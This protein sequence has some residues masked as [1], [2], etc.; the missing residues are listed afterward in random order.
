LRPLTASE[1]RGTWGTVL[2]PIDDHERI[3]MA[4]LDAE[5]DALLASGVNGIYTNGTAGE[6]YTQTEAEFDRIH[7]RIAGRCEA[8]GMPYQIGASHMSPQICL[9]R[10]RRVVGYAPSAIQVVLPDWFPVSD[11]EAVAFLSRV[12]EAAA[13]VGL[14]LYNPPHAKRVLRPED[15]DKLKA[16][17]PALVGIKVAGGEAEWYARMQEAGG[18]LSVFVPGHRLATGIRYG[19]A[20]SYSNMACLNPVAAQLWYQLMLRDLDAA[21]AVERRIRQFMDVHIVPYIRDRKYAN[22]ALDKLLA[23][24]GGWAAIGTRLRWPY[25]WIDPREAEGLRRAARELIPE[26]VAPDGPGPHPTG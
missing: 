23:E 15:F 13:P 16:A 11:E 3:D 10:V 12:A 19:A 1:I 24:I 4:R 20:G 5:I 6:F 25:R 14:V 18:G 22:H 9:E 8:A 21:L 7:E 17:V 2:L 26:F